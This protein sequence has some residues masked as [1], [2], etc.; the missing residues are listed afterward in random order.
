MTTDQN[1]T[2]TFSGGVVT[3]LVAYQDGA[4]VSREIVRK[5]ASNI[6]M[7]AFDKGQ[8]LSEHSAPF[9]AI[10]HVI[11]GL[12]EIYIAGKPNRVAA[13]ELILMP[14]NVPHSLKAI[15]R[16]KMML[17]MIREPQA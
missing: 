2:S 13:G 11:D 12:A 16:F 15:E 14:A 4:V 3:D 6:T 10:V 17:I 7:F 5:K 8:G 1:S 9:D